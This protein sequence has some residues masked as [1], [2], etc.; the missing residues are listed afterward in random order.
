ML[1]ITALSLNLRLVGGLSK[2]WNHLHTHIP[3]HNRTFPAPLYNL[4]HVFF[5]PLVF[6]HFN[7]TLPRE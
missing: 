4:A 6:Q 7:A 2:G 3:L 1:L 5:A